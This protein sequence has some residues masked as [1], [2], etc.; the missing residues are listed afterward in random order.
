MS[1]DIPLIRTD[2]LTAVLDDLAADVVAIVNGR[3][4]VDARN[5]SVQVVS[6]EDRTTL[7]I[8]VSWDPDEVG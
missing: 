1:A 6:V 4:D 5:D 2:S 8:V 7:T 3:F